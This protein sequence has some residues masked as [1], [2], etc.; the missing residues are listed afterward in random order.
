[1]IHGADGVERADDP[2]VHVLQPGGIGRVGAHRRQQG[3]VEID[4]AVDL[5]AGFLVQPVQGRLHAVD[6]APVGHH[7][8][9]IGPV[10][11]EHPV[12]QKVILAGIDPA[13]AV[14][15]AHHRA[16]APMLDGDLEGQQVAFAGGGFG[17]FGAE[18]IAAGLLVVQ[19]IVLDGRDHM[20]VLG[21]ADGLAGQGPGQQ[22]ILAQIFEIAPVARIAGQVDTAAEQQ[23]EA[24][25][26]SL[27]AGDLTALIGDLGAPGG[28]R[29]QARRQGGGPVAPQ[30]GKIGDAQAGVGLLERGQAET[31]DPRHIAGARHGVRRHDDSREDGHGDDPMDQGQ[32][33]LRGQLMLDDQGSRIGA[34]RIRIGPIRRESDARPGAQTRQAAAQQEG[35]APSHGARPWLASDGLIRPRLCIHQKNSSS[36]WS[37]LAPLGTR[38]KPWPPRS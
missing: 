20:L 8:A 17:D 35:M 18:H 11:L 4:L 6:G 2:V 36:Q 29:G 28:G 37:L 34:L 31:R 5:L 1:M 30:A 23:V 33:F 27:L 13:I 14:V 15:A 19:R 24:F 21:S 9:G 12:E 32:L 16:G 10:V 22:R 3:L 26:P 25:A 38:P 7:P